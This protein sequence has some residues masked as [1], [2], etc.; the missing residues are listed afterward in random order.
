[1]I[2]AI[3]AEATGPSLVHGGYGSKFY[4]GIGTDTAGTRQTKSL[5]IEQSL[6]QRGLR[7][8]PLVGDQ[9]ARIYPRTKRLP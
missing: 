2:E 3:Q 1:M 9:P 6:R 4:G 5:T 7:L 8:L